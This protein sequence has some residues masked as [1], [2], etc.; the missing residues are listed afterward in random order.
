MI[1]K[2]HIEITKNALINIFSDN[3]IKMIINANTQQ[4]QLK[5]Q[6]NHDHIHFDGNSFVEGKLYIAIQENIMMQAI[7]AA[8]FVTARQAFGRLTHSWQDFYSHSNYV[9]LWINNHGYCRPE[10]IDPHDD[11]LINHPELKSGVS[12]G[13]IEF[14]ALMPILSRII[15]PLMPANSHAQMNLDKPSS[16]YFFCYAYQAALK[17]TRSITEQL[18][19]QLIH[20]DINPMNVTNFKYQSL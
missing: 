9:S 17:Q 12:Y 14:F 18:F 11:Y 3:A 6:F 13:L 4:D 16:G 20:S 1:K 2:Y 15:K 5:F 10:E 19:M 7:Q 8:D